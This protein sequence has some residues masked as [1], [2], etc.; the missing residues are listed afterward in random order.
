MFDVKNEL[1]VLRLLNR[2][3]SIHSAKIVCVFMTPSFSPLGGFRERKMFLLAYSF[4]F[5]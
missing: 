2:Y 4:V 1:E 3:F 5:H